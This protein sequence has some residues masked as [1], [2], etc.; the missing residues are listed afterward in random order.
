MTLW[1]FF[2]GMLRW[3]WHAG[4]VVW[5]EAAMTLLTRP[6]WIWPP[7]MGSCFLSGI[8]CWIFS[9]NN[10]TNYDLFR[11]HGCAICMVCVLP[12]CVRLVCREVWNT[13]PGGICLIGICCNSFTRMWLGSIYLDGQWTIHQKQLC[14]NIHYIIYYINVYVC[15][16]CFKNLTQVESH[17]RPGLLL[18][19]SWGTRATPSL[20]QGTCCA[21]EWHW[22]F[23]FALLAPFDLWLSSLKE[24]HFQITPECKRSSH[25][26]L[27]PGR[28]LFWK[29]FWHLKLVS[30][31]LTGYTYMAHICL[32]SGVLWIVLDGCI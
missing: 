23:G 12:S 5:L 16:S 8:S 25:V 32:E 19:P 6:W 17:S 13:K 7:P 10:F 20:R 29:K 28:L 2:L 30:H 18:T 26:L 22:Y 31:F 27:L 14:N 3:L 1:S 24:A 11:M 4:T 15:A 9:R 21:R